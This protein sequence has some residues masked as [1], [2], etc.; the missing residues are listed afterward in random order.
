MALNGRP[1]ND[2]VDHGGGERSGVGDI[3]APVAAADGTAGATEDEINR[4]AGA[5]G[6]GDTVQRQIRGVH[7]GAARG[8]GDGRRARVHGEG[9]EGFRRGR[10]SAAGIG[11]VPALQGDRGGILHAVVVVGQT[12]TVIDLEEAAVDCDRRRA[13]ETPVIDEGELA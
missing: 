6:A 9:A 5:G 4:G 8:Y 1:G 13:A 12:V 2:V 11:D 10:L 7:A 3:D